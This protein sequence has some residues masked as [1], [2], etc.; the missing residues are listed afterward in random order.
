[1][2]VPYDHQEGAYPLGRWLSDQRR[3]YRA[4]TMPSTRADELE[5][6]GM[7]WDTADTA[8]TEN[9]AA[10]RAYH[11]QARTLAA[12]RHATALDKPVGQWLT[13]LR[14]PSGLGK[15]PERAQRRAEQLAAIDP[16]WNPGA[17]GWT[18][19]WQRHY[20]GLAALL[21]GGAGLE[22]IVPGVTHRG[23]DIGRWL[24]RQVR[25][26]TRLNP[27]QQHRLNELGV[28][29]AAQPHKAPARANAK[30]GA[31]KGSDAFTRGVAALAQYI[32]REGKTVVGRQ[33]V[34]VLPDGTTVRLGIFL[35]NQKTRRHRL[36]DHQLAALAN[37][38]LEWA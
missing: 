34:E 3:A 6:L 31:A 35:T 25:D 27:E 15:D 21:A 14:R 12:P 19:D 22:E 23:D 9:L 30:A 36:T 29:P 13:N 18:V 11:A 24:T 37:L 20:T 33:H 17:L 10:A 1:M 4:G 26:W 2:D 8:F 7:I 5:E 32:A 28:K 38:G 16:D